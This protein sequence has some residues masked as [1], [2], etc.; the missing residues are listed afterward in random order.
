MKKTITVSVWRKLPIEQYGNIE[1]Y[2][3][4]TEEYEENENVDVQTRRK[5]IRED[6]LLQ[7][8]EDKKLIKWKRE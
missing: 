6:L 8:A 2:Y 7:L 4:H 1:F 3:S 5:E